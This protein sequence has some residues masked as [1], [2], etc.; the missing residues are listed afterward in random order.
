ML[1]TNPGELLPELG[2][3]LKHYM[4]ASGANVAGVISLANDELGYILPEKDFVYP[5]NPLEPGDHYEETVSVGPKIG[6]ILMTSS[7]EL[8]NNLAHE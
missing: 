1:I 7:K 6:T 4:K 2:L 5:E 3:E 8:I